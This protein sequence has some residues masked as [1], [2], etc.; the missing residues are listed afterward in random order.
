[1]VSLN[2][3]NKILVLT[4]VL[5]GLAGLPLYAASGPLSSTLESSWPQRRNGNF[6]RLQS[7]QKAGGVADAVSEV[8]VLAL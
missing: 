5:Q 6:M 4:M 2:S 8:K 7:R 3:E 1:M